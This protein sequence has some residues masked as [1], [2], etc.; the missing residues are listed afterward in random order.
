MLN[1]PGISLSRSI[2]FSPLRQRRRSS[3]GFLTCGTLVGSARA[4]CPH[5]VETVGIHILHHI[6]R[7]VGR[8]A[9]PLARCRPLPTRPLIIGLVLTGGLTRDRRRRAGPRYRQRIAT[10]RITQVVDREVDM[11][12]RFIDIGEHLLTALDLTGQ[13]R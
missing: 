5:R 10:S 7:M 2:A 3:V 12:E 8:Y 1:K 9:N 6:A 11:L 4:R 13:P